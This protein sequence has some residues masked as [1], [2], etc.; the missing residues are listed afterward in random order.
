MQRGMLGWL[1]NSNWRKR[2]SPNLRC[3]P[4][5]CVERLRK[6]KK[7]I[8]MNSIGLFR[9]KYEPEMF[10]L[11]FLSRV[12]VV[13]FTALSYMVNVLTDFGSIVTIIIHGICT[14]MHSLLGGLRVSVPI[15]DCDLRALHGL[16]HEFHLGRLRSDF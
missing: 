4:E 12:S 11:L 15:T 9:P 13:T 8:K 14:D 7:I 16:Q 6:V 3:Y 2:S 5:T 10:W 1:A